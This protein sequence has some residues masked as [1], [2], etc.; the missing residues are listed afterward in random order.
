MHHVEHA[1]Q[2]WGPEPGPGQQDSCHHTEPIH[3]ADHHGVPVVSQPEQTFE[4]PKVEWD[5]AR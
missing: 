2:H 5:A 4:A 3:T 1:G